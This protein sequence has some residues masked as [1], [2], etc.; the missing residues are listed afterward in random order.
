MN[1][2][3]EKEK[4]TGRYKIIITSITAVAS[5]VGAVLGAKF[6]PVEVNV[7]LDGYVSRVQDEVVSQQADGAEITL[8][9]LHKKITELQKDNANQQQQIITLENEK[10]ELLDVITE[11][12]RI[13]DTLTQTSPSSDVSNI[14]PNQPAKDAVKLTS[15]T[16][17][18]NN[19]GGT[20]NYVYNSLQNNDD[21]KSNL[22]EAFNSSV[23]MR[24]N[25]DIDFYLAGS[26]QTLNATISIS[27]STKNISDY[28]STLTIYSVDGN[29]SNETLEVLYTSPSITMGFI[30]DEIGPINVSGV[31][32]LRISFYAS[33][34]VYSVPRIV[35]GNP[36]LMPI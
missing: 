35:L 19:D 17:L 10:K 1:Q 34:G 27:E 13:I 30:P 5:I 4:I 32:H 16:I 28:S 8:N 23:S 25:G 9:D 2:G 21:A 15:L 29:G 7:N 14:T 22:G 26:Y 24:R 12:D 18:G 20:Y 33:G 31:E 11:K 6:A 3:F 36:E